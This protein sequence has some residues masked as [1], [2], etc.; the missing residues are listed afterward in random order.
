MITALVTGG[1]GMLGSHVVDRLLLDGA[2]VRV[3]ARSARG[4]GFLQERGVEVAE[5]DLLD[6]P[7]LDRAVAGT[8]VVYHVAAAIG[9]DSDH[10][11]YQL[12][13]V[14]GTLNVLDAAARRG[15]RMVYVSSTSVFGRHRFFDRPTDESTPLPELPPADAYG[16]SKQEAE[17]RVLAAHHAGRAWVTVVRPPVMYG[18]RDRQFVPRLAPVLR[19]GVF[20]L[21]AGGTARMTLVHGDA[22]ARGMIRASC[23]DEA[24][25]QVYHLTDDFPVTVRSMVEWAAKGLGVRM[26][27]IP[28]PGPVGAAGFTLLG[29]A[30]RLV[31]REDL[32]RHAPGTHTMLTRDNPFSS[33]RA[34]DEL[35]WTPE[36]RP[37]EGLPHAFRWWR[38]AQAGASAAAGEG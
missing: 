12:G 21:V 31:G 20:P 19:R 1:T 17:Q 18:L 5:G 32:A 2:R 37:E 13:N 4:T 27:F 6:P 10:E 35:G 26:R 7:S 3:L 34:R 23:R 25:G 9:S 36:I 30:L 22:V 16:R 11:T 8:E 15:A 24:G 38:D 14:V 33:Q 29:L 28:V